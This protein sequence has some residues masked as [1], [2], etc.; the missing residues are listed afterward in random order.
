MPKLSDII[1]IKILRI[2]VI[3]IALLKHFSHNSLQKHHVHKK[4][5]NKYQDL[6]CIGHLS[7][8]TEDPCSW[9]LIQL[10]NI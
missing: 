5:L 2:R 4:S 10:Q 1:E 7:K 3:L 6:L 8:K 9:F